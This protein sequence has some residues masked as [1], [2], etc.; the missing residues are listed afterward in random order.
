MRVWQACR[1]G[2]FRALL[3]QPLAPKSDICLL[4]VLKDRIIGF[5]YLDSTVDRNMFTEEDF[6]LGTLFAN[7][8]NKYFGVA[9]DYWRLREKLR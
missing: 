9:L 4:F 7:K 2:D 6:M 8:A 1:R 3:P 5:L